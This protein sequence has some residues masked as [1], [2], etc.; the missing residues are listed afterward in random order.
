MAKLL[1]VDVVREAFWPVT[2]GLFREGDGVMNVQGGDTI[3]VFGLE[4]HKGMV[5]TTP[6]G[7]VTSDGINN[8]AFFTT[9][10]GDGEYVIEAKLD[11][12]ETARVTVKAH[13]EWEYPGA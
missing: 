8:S 4:N 7:D 5:V 11:G 3:E 10:K 1:I 13:E 2:S 6:E 9:P 12:Y